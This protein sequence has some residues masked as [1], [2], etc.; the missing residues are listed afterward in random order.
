MPTWK[1]SGTFPTS[2]TLNTSVLEKSLYAFIC[3]HKLMVQ[4]FTP[5]LALAAWMGG[6]GRTGLSLLT[7]GS[8]RMRRVWGGDTAHTFPQDAPRAAV[9]GI[10]VSAD[11]TQQ[12]RLSFWVL[13]RCGI[14]PWHESCWVSPVPVICSEP[15]CRG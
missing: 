14:T 8:R 4:V 11:P 9:L 2:V 3:A 7:G 12:L 13:S 5:A 1:A 15:G 6:E 10:S